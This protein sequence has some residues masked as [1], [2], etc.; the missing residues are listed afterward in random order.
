MKSQPNF[1]SG[2]FV[3]IDTFKVRKKNVKQIF[4]LKRN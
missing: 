4:N 1:I 2:Y 3:V